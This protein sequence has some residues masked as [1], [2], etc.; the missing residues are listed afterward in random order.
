MS[1]LDDLGKAAGDIIR[2]AAPGLAAALGGPFAGLAAQAL[3]DN[4]LPGGDV[5]TV[6]A[7][8]AAMSPADIAMLKKVE[9]DFIVAMEQAGIDRTK[10]VY[11]DIANARDREKTLRDWVPATLGL[12][13]TFGFFGIVAY[14]CLRALP[15]ANEQVLTYM[16]GSLN[17]AW[18]SVVAYYYGSSRG[19]DKKTELL[20]TTK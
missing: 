19:S 1:F 17:T 2:G 10:L 13:I 4:V 20:G 12:M 16:L 14:M 6:G 18:I 3:I 8:I 7:K 11:A 15:S 9:N 5:A